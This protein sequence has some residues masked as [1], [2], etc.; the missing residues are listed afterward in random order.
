MNQRRPSP[1]LAQSQQR[2]LQRMLD[3]SR[4]VH[5]RGFKQERLA[6]TGVDQAYTGP[7]WLP[8]D[9]GQAPDELR[10]AMKH[11]L[12]GDYPHEY[13]EVIRRYYELVYADVA[14]GALAPGDGSALP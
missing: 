9:L 4:S 14:Q 10:E 6:E 3:A 2:I 8:G 5:T 12:A 1:R 11:A 13:W 7:S